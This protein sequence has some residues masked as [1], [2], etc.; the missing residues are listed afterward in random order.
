MYFWQLFWTISILVAGA[1][2]AFITVVVT[3][4][5]VKDLREMFKQLGKQQGNSGGE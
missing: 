5:G 3:F 4:K 1:A 2:F